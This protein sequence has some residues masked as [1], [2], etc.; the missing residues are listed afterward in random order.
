MDRQVLTSI[1]M[2]HFSLWEKLRQK[3]APLAFTLEITARCNNKCRHCYINLPAEDP[4][5]KSEELTLNEI[6]SIAQQACDMGAF[7]CLITGGEPLLRSDFPDIY[8]GLKRKGFLISI[9]TNATLIQD[10]HVE[11]FKQYP[12]RNMEVT[13]Y[14]V[15]QATYETV[16][17]REGSFGAFQRGLQRLLD[18][19]VPVHLKGM[20]LRSNQHE[21]PQ[22]AGF[23]RG[24]TRDY[25]RW[26]PFL[27][28]RYDRNRQRNV[29]IIAERL[30][31]EEIVALEQS[32]PER[33]PAIQKECDSRVHEEI[34]HH[35]CDHLLR[36]GA[37]KEH[38]AV[39][40]NGLFRLCESLWAPGTTYDL[41]KG[42]LKQAW[43]EFVPQVRDLRSH[44]A[45]Y[46]ETC[47]T[48]PIIELC[49]SCPAHND[50]ETGQM[51][52]ETPYFCAVAHARAKMLETAS[53]QK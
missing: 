26:D 4:Q 44:N 48:C 28:L 11:L 21:L 23:C 40:Y 30:T 50:L 24:H 16:T 38:F 25:Y 29:E 6:L 14:G 43:N 2:Q 33:F 9:F 20:A 13:V 27:N 51:D 36:C 52:G 37:G 3:R 39:S 35:G 42:N 1:K 22:I 31:P 15:T 5:A 19:R 47:Q 32:D 12:P 41:R 8:L 34:G 7:W 49:L 17:R 53:G 18:N 45:A 46:L 10:R